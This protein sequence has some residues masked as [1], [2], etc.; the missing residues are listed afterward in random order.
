[1]DDDLFEYTDG[2]YLQCYDP[3]VDYEI[4]DDNE[5][6]LENASQISST[7]R[8]TTTEGT[9]IDNDYDIKEI[10]FDHAAL[11]HAKSLAISN[12]EG[13]EQE[14]TDIDWLAVD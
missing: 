14:E 7:S 8:T 1:M 4:L 2:E 11:S 12:F 5:S 3:D 6:Y 13:P 10:F 9:I